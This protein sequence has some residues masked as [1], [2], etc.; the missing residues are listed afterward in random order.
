ML[1]DFPSIFN[2][3]QPVLLRDKLT[4]MHV[5]PHLVIGLLTI[6]LTNQAEE[7]LIR[8]NDQQHR[9]ATNNCTAL[10]FHALYIGHQL[11]QVLEWHSCSMVV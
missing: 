3:V 6:R 8:D 2:T 10:L 9:N 7:L 11:Q 4:G 1:F 5:G